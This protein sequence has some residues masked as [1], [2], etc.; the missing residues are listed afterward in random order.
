LDG[1][2]DIRYD[3]KGAIPNVF[4][5]SNHG[6]GLHL[7]L[8]DGSVKVLENDVSGSEQSA[9]VKVVDDDTIELLPHNNI[10]T[11]QKA[12]LKRRK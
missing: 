9:S 2:Y 11:M 12:I 8:A 3:R 4:W 10:G 1:P 7:V 6:E 5:S